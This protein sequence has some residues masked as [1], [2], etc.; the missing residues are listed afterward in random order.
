MFQIEII[1]ILTVFYLQ[2]GKKSSKTY[3]VKIKFPSYL[4]PMELLLLP[5]EAIIS[6][7]RDFLKQSHVK[8]TI[9]N[10]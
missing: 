6:S 2:G 4:G 1:I 10:F 9:F 7:C 8:A 3:K 5:P